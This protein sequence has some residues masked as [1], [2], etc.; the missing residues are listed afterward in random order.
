MYIPCKSTTIKIIGVV[1]RP[2]LRLNH[3]NPACRPRFFRPTQVISRPIGPIEGKTIKSTLGDPDL[4][5][6]IPKWSLVYWCDWDIWRSSQKKMN[7]QVGQSQLQLHHLHH[8]WGITVAPPMCW[9]RKMWKQI[10]LALNM[11]GHVFEPSDSIGYPL[12]RCWGFQVAS[13]NEKSIEK[14]PDT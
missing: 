6:Y 8:V 11:Y 14:A 4:K 13:L 9:R 2:F 7:I 5:W 12:M 10:C 1:Q 3:V